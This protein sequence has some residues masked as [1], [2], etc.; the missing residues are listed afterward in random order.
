M[1]TAAPPVGRKRK[2]VE[3]AARAPRTDSNLLP[4]WHADVARLSE[5]LWLP[6]LEDCAQGTTRVGLANWY[7]TRLLVPEKGVVTKRLGYEHALLERWLEK[8]EGG[9]AQVDDPSSAANAKKART[10]EKAAPAPAKDLK[11]R[12]IRVY[13]AN[14]AQDKLLRKCFGTSRWIYN[15]CLKRL[16][17]QPTVFK[18]N[19]KGGLREAVVNDGNYQTEKQWVLETPRDIRAGAYNDLLAAYSSNFAKK[20]KTPTHHFDV[21]FRSAKAPQQ[22]IYIGKRN[23]NRGVIYPKKVWQRAAP[24]ERTA[25][26]TL[27]PR[28]PFDPHASW[29]LLS[30]HQCGCETGR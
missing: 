26:R 16:R 7:T 30:L 28:R 19:V 10:E 4:F 20:K 25:A 22:R 5:H 2:R 17:E 23:Y 13:P 24:C 8:T 14:E 21:A 29:P 27:V 15:E 18:P 12:K 1:A 3:S 6:T 11:T 9:K